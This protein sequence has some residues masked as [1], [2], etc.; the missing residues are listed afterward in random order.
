MKFYGVNNLITNELLFLGAVGFGICGYLTKGKFGL[1][2][3]GL[4]FLMWI[5]LFIESE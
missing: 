2:I 1:M 4:S 3:T 5:L